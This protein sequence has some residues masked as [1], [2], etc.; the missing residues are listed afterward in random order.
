MP[1]SGDL[2]V[3]TTWRV[4][5]RMFI[6]DRSGP[7]L[8][9]FAIS[10]VFGAALSRA[11]HEPARKPAL[12]VRR[13]KAEPARKPALPVRRAKDKPSTSTWKPRAYIHLK[14]R[15]SRSASSTT[16]V[17]PCW[18]PWCG[19]SGIPAGPKQNTSTASAPKMWLQ[20]Q[21]YPI[22]DPRSSRPSPAQGSLST[23]PLS[24]AHSLPRSYGLPRKSNTRC[25]R[26]PRSM[27]SGTPTT[28]TGV[29]ND[30]TSPPLTLASNGPAPVIVRSTTVQPREQSGG[31]SVIDARVQDSLSELQ[32][33]HRAVR[34]KDLARLPDLTG[35][36]CDMRPADPPRTRRP[37]LP[38]GHIE[39]QQ[40]TNDDGK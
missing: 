37:R 5:S 32:N 35:A 18:T 21:S 13:A 24:T 10:Y 1:A 40:E 29:G 9:S 22:S 7:G 20:R 4:L 34:P 31:T 38:L 12:P 30:F 3:G 8:K 16:R 28:K 11:K 25:W 2:A 33:N 15:S 23:T 14:T 6:S 39:V 26:S 17:S 19:R 36:A 27:A